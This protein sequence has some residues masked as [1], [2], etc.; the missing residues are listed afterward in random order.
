MID[1]NTFENIVIELMMSIFPYHP[2]RL[3]VYYHR[4]TTTHQSYHLIGNFNKIYKGGQSICIS[5]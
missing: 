1:I 3:L 5:Q 2:A 4:I